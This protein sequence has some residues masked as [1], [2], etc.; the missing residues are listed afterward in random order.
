MVK[1]VNGS[2]KGKIGPIKHGYKNYLFLWHR[3]FALSNGIFV[4]NCRNVTI[5]GAEFMKGA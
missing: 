4:E 3:D 2:N 1:C 5:L